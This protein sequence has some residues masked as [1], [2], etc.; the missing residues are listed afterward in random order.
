MGFC[1]KLDAGLCDI[2]ENLNRDGFDFGFL[3]NTKL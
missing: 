2:N 3:K 1:L